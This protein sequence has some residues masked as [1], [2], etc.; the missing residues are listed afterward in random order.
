MKTIK[1]IYEAMFT[2]FTECNKDPWCIEIECPR[3]GICS[4]V[5]TAMSELMQA[6]EYH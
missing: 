2:H 4:I 6:G 1:D 3:L 5:A